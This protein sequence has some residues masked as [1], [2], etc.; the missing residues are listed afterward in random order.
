MLLTPAQTKQ[1]GEQLAVDIDYTDFI[2][3]RTVTSI[4]PVVTTPSGITLVNQLLSGN[5]LQ[6]LVGGGTTGTTYRWR[7]VTS[8]VISGLTHIVEG[9]FDTIVQEI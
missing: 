5:V 4:T 9:E 6:L 1:P 3:G 2:A 7:V 8:I